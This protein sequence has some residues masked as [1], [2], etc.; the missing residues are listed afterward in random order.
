MRYFAA[1]VAAVALAF[2]GHPATSAPLSPME[3]LARQLGTPK[4]GWTGR[5]DARTHSMFEWV[6]A[7]ETVNNWTKIFTVVASSVHT[8]DTQSETKATIQRIRKLL[9]QRHAHVNAFDVRDQ[10][11]PVAYFDYVMQ[12]EVNVGVIFSPHPGIVTIQQVAAHHSGVITT[13]D[14]RHIQ[15]LIGY[16]G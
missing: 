6:P 12:G 14:V 15:A 4:I 7:G 9:T 3:T 8:A 1:A 11:P 13:Q 16:P 5:N 10:A 2:A